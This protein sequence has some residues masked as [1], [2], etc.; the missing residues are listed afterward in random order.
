MPAMPQR[1]VVKLSNFDVTDPIDL[2]T[3][4]ENLNGKTEFFIKMLKRIDVTSVMPCLT[5]VAEGL[6]EKDWDKMKQGAHQLKG[7][8]GYVGAGRVHYCCYHI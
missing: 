4:V 5:Q 2:I 8:S 7:S 6:N 1:M 3:P